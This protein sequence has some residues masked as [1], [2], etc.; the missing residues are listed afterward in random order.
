VQYRTLARRSSLPGRLRLAA[1]TVAVAFMPS[2]GLG[3]AGGDRARA[4]G[5]EASVPPL[6]PEPAPP[7]PV[8]TDARAVIVTLD[9]VRWQDVFQGADPDLRPGEVAAELARRPV[10]LMPR[11]HA[12]VA[13]RGIA[14]GADA[15]GP[16][17]DAGAPCGIVRTASGANVSLPGYLE[18]F[19][20]RATRCRDNQCPRTLAPTLLDEVVSAGRG[21]VASVGSWEILDHAVSRGDTGVFVAAGRQPWP[22]SRPLAE[23]LER[24]VAAGEAADA[25]PGVGSYRP[26]AHTAAIALEVFRTTG[27]ALFHL[28]L[29]D[30]DEWGHKDDYAAY[31]TSLQEADA[32]IGE[33]ATTL[34]GMGE[35]GAATLVVVTS[36]HGRNASFQHHGALH[37]ESGRT[38]IA[39]F[40]RRMVPRGV[41]C[42]ATEVT[43]ADVAPTLRVVMGLRA[44]RSPDAGR[45]IPEILEALRR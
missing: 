3:H 6:G 28:G 21:P 11:L 5:L 35:R 32:A 31:L 4:S 20:G 44:D 45:P 16:L 38:W 19:T 42:P 25:H 41:T 1:L 36:D 15:S 7:P 10:A 37:V 26:D 17:L 22:A 33:L 12:L 18:I 8:A 29:G 34:D 24:L 13:S 23:P 9:G 39:A 2:C 40:G 27:P 30:P 43:L 14:L